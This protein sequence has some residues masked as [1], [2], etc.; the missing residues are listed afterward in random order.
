MCA[1]G[2]TPRPC[3]STASGEGALNAFDVHAVEEALRVKEA[4][5]RR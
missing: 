3:G 4:H 1:S 2:S 5:G